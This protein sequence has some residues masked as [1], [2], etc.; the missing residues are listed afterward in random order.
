MYLLTYQNHGGYEQNESKLD[1]VHTTVDFGKLTDDI[2]EY[3]TSV[4][5]SVDAFGDLITYFK[6]CKEPTIIC[7]VGDHAPSFINQL[8]TELGMEER[9]LYSRLVP[10]VIWANYEIE[11][12]QNEI[13]D[14]ASYMCMTDFIPIIVEIADLPM[15]SYYNCIQ[16]LQ[17]SI[18]IRTSYGKYYDQNLNQILFS[19]KELLQKYYFMEYNSLKAG[20]SYKRE[21]FIPIYVEQ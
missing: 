14:R 17:K 6:N 7:M 12:M 11:S 8:D 1:R 21:L 5:M 13:V 4:S 19:D 2:N 18:P 3:I 15:T 9:E 16:E 20:E 10:Y